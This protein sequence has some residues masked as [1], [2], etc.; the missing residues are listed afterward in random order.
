MAYKNWLINFIILTAVVL[1]NCCP[2]SARPSS[3]PSCK[4]IASLAPSNTEL[5]YSLGAQNRLVGVSTFCDYPED[6]G[7]KEKIGSF[8]SV[9]LE[10]LAR[11]NPDAVL[12]VDGQESIAG[13]LR[14]QGYRVVVLNNKRLEAISKNLVAIGAITG[15][16]AESKLLAKQFE[17]QL[18]SLRRIMSSAKTRPKVFYCVW[19]KPLLT[20]GRSSFLNGVITTCGGKNIASDLK[21]AYPQFSL[22]KLAVA[23]P[24]LIILPRE[25]RDSKFLDGPPWSNLKAVKNKRVY[26]LP[27]SAH[28]NLSR[29]TLRVTEGLFW[30]ASTIHPELKQR[31]E[32]WR[33]SCKSANPSRLSGGRR[34]KMK[35][36]SGQN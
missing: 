14:R 18:A 21:A 2:T 24:D 6:A 30:L 22:E 17:G 12:L 25:A 19:P 13:I 1:T 33:L 23:N 16:I 34:P 11:L 15:K 8:V 31:L 10:R 32:E 36:I 29:P 26:F 7:S 27:E 35:K 28:D 9:N 20:A 4:R 3:G 5:I